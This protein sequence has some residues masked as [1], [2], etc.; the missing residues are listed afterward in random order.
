MQLARLTRQRGRFEAGAHRFRRRPC[1]VAA[2]VLQLLDLK[3]WTRPD[4]PG[5]GK[6][7]GVGWRRTVLQQC[8]QRARWDEGR[9]GGQRRAR[10]SRTRAP[11]MRAERAS[12]AIL[13]GGDTPKLDGHRPSCI[14]RPCAQQRKAARD[15]RSWFAARQH[16]RAQGRHGR[17]SV[18][19][20]ARARGP[21]HL[22]GRRP[23][24]A[25]GCRWLVSLDRLVV[26]GGAGFD[27]GTVGG[28]SA[29]TRISLLGFPLELRGPPHMTQESF[30][31]PFT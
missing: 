1:C 12:P 14:E 25:G 3:R 4:L 5:E 16:P 15:E 27:I 23:A 8:T 7:E 18:G 21:D 10:G 19:C 13:A 29:C 17:G 2:S 6:R 26:C 24:T 31:R 30:R 28:A 11:G 9:E 20:L 22:L